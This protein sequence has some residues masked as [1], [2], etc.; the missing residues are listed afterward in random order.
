MADNNLDKDI[1]DAVSKNQNPDVLLQELHDRGHSITENELRGRL[2][3]LDGA[4][5]NVIKALGGKNV[6][7]IPLF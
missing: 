3:E 7:V 4:Y 5:I 2:L 1:L 6:R